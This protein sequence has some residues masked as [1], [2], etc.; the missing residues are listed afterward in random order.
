MVDIRRGTNAYCDVSDVREIVCEPGEQFALD[1]L[2]KVR[3]AIID[4]CDEMRE[5]R[6]AAG[7]GEL[8]AG[9]ARRLNAMGAVSGMG[10][11]RK[12][13]HCDH[14]A[15]QYTATLRCW[16]PPEPKPAK[17]ATKTPKPTEAGE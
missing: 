4:V 8:P 9:E 14:M 12:G 3:Q 17:K 5:A 16:A 10:V 7:L 6:A 13:G 11:G 15:Y 1:E 2:D